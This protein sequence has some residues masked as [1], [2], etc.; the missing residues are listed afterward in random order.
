MGSRT[1]R[2]VR[3]LAALGPLA[4]S[5]PSLAAPGDNAVGVNAHIGIAPMVDAAVELGVPWL[6][7]DGNWRDLEPADG[8]YAWAALDSWVDRARAAGVNVYLTL[9][10]TPAWVPRHGDTDGDPGNDVPNA[11]TEWVRFVDRAVRRYRARGVTHFGLWN[12]PNLDHF[13]EGSIEEY[14]TLI[15]VPGAAAVRAACADCTVLGPDLAHVGDVDVQLERLLRHIPLAT[16][17]I[18]AHHIYGGFPETG[19]QVWDGDRFFN[20]LD[21][22]RF[23]FTRRSLRQVLD[24][25]GW[26]GEVWIT[27]TGYRADPAGD[28]QREQN[29]AIYVRRVIEEMLARAWYTN[30]FFYEM[31]DCRPFQPA[32]DIDGFGLLR[33]TGT[34]DLGTASFPADFRQKPAFLELK[35]QI[36]AHPQL[37]GLAPPP[38]CGNGR[39][40][41]G[42]GRVDALDRG[43]AD[44]VDVDESDDPP[45]LRLVARG[46]AAEPTL[47]GVLDERG[48]S[49]WLSLGPDRWAGTEPLSGPADL[50]VRVTAGWTGAGL[51]LG[52]E[53]D[54]DVADNDRPDPELW[55]GDSVQLAFDL[56]RN[57]GDAYDATDDHEINVALARGAARVFRFHGPAGA[58]T[59]TRAAVVRRGA[60]TV[61]EILIPAADLGR[62]G[63]GAGNR[64]GFSFLVNDADGAGRTGWIEWTPGIG[65][66]K[67]P[68]W[69][70]ELELTAA[71]PIPDAG[72]PPDAGPGPVDA[73]PPIDA[74]A[75]ADAAVDAGAALDAGTT[76][77]AAPPLDAGTPGTD[78]SAANDAGAADAGSSPADAGAT[79]E[80][81]G[82]GADGGCGCAA[83]RPTRGAPAEAWAVALAL[84]G[85]ALRR[86]GK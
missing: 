83:N 86:R 8:Q 37:S 81:G 27:E 46:L 23:P 57:L 13:F 85:L 6:R 50:S 80:P 36:L 68:Y 82:T 1:L 64:F 54:D 63:V 21:Q 44:A 16:Y 38:A 61:Y 58:P 12:E 52:L 28:A 32:C 39:D 2:V 5:A 22:Q 10:Y 30:T 15:A 40:D 69:F 17:D 60:T 11:S 74:G 62:R 65:R 67:A 48:A 25:V 70:G 42:D 4:S 49:P 53:V 55:Q 47:D 31:I 79:T 72:T 14:G 41:D 75:P 73:G 7:F 77:D 33:S 18:L 51:W 43:C 29:Q 84:L 45:R 20:A 71:G 66:G 34:T 56:A 19:T 24:A 9:A 78:A 76:P 3:L 59:G 35:Q 26:T